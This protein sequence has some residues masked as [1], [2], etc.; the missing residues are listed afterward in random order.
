MHL[1]DLK[2]G[3]SCDAFEGH[4]GLGV[5][6]PCPTLRP[7][8]LLSYR[9]RHQGESLE[10]GSPSHIDSALLVFCHKSILIIFSLMR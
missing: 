4:L 5:S 8:M 10:K 6:V 9:P 7:G 2:S 1:L 3:R